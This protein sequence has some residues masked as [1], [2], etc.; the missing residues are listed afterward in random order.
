MKDSLHQ[1]IQTYINCYI[2][3]E[4]GQS[5][6]KCTMIKYINQQ[7]KT[8]LALL[9]DE[10]TDPFSFL[11]YPYEQIARL[12]EQCESVNGLLDKPIDP[13]ALD[14]LSSTVCGVYDCCKQIS[15]YIKDVTYV[16][17]PATQNVDTIIQ[18]N[19]LLISNVKSKTEKKPLM[20]REEFLKMADDSEYLDVYNGPDRADESILRRYGY[21]V[22]QDSLLS[23]SARQDL[24]RKLIITN[25][26]SKGYVISYLEHIIQINGRKE[27]NYIALSK[28]K[29]DL[30]YVLK[31]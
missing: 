24:L 21:S 9:R 16:Q 6:I 13:T 12:I 8:T 22:A 30:Q 20:T 7:C 23:D 3:S 25:T 15:T 29:Q 10:A 2:E 28:W 5:L 27:T 11:Y 17:T 18:N 14:Q 1:L 31:L 26:V 19:N 4:Q